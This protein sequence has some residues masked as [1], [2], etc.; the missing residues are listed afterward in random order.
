L[1]AVWQ[2]APVDGRTGGT[3]QLGEKQQ[4]ASGQPHRQQSETGNRRAETE[5]RQLGQS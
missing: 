1:R 2:A 4:A 3:G 5:N